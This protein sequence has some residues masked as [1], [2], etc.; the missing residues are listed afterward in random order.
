MK[1]LEWVPQFIRHERQRQDKTQQ[2]LAEAAGLSKTQ[3]SKI[4][5]AR[6]IPTLETLDRVLVGLELSFAEFSRRYLEMGRD[7]G[8]KAEEGVDS[9]ATELESSGTALSPGLLVLVDQ[10]ARGSFETAEHYVVVIPKRS[11]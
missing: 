11:V 2:Q 6:Q 8:W 3:I 5:T 1:I 4:E 7:L 10:I 9:R